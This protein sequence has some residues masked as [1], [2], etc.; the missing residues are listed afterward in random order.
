MVWKRPGDRPCISIDRPVVWRQLGQPQSTGARCPGLS[1]D[2]SDRRRTEA[3]AEAE[4]SNSNS[5]QLL[6]LG[7]T[8]VRFPAEKKLPPFPLSPTLPLISSL[9]A[10]AQPTTRHLVLSLYLS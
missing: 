7:V 3:E 5:N 9:L 1:Q 2:R 4:G 10:S 8:G 6:P